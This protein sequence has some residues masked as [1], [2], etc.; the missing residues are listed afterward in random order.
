MTAVFA[1][2]VVGSCAAV[3]FWLND[4]MRESERRQAIAEQEFKDSFARAMGKG[5][6][7][8]KVR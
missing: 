4:G 2:A 6:R 8:I 7:R 5:K 3:L 1:F